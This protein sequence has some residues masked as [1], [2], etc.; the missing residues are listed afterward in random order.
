M[1]SPTVIILGG[2]GSL[3][4]DSTADQV[5]LKGIGMKNPR[6]G[7]V[8]LLVAACVSEPAGFTAQ[9]RSIVTALEERYRTGWLA[10]DTAAVMSTL[11]SDAVLMPAGVEPVIGE[12]AIRSYWWP[13]DGSR[14]TIT[15][16]E[17]M[18]HEVEGDGSLAYLR[19]RGDLAFTYVDTAGEAR[20][21]TS[22]AAHLSVARRG[23]DGEW[24]IARR[25]WSAIR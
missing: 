13:D 7:T 1:R 25:V 22:R 12:A 2:G 15:S 17:I 23:D 8:V 9:D 14:T 4:P 6:A 16:Y 5:R 24:R 21:L 11:T 19:G 20:N 3:V 18:V 10:N